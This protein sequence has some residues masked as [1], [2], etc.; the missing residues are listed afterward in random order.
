MT[1]AACALVAGTAAVFAYAHYQSPK[2]TVPPDANY[3]VFDWLAVLRL[4]N[5][6]SQNCCNHKIDMD[7][8]ITLIFGI[9]QLIFVLWFTFS[10]VEKLKRSERLL[11]ELLRTANPNH[12]DF[13][14]PAEPSS[15]PYTAEQI[16]EV[17]SRL[18]KAKKRQVNRRMA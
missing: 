9:I 13:V 5:R 14:T 16:K 4:S 17:M 18:E 10:V 15:E 7:S 3:S 2:R 12:P 6:W 1:A 8:F 11:R